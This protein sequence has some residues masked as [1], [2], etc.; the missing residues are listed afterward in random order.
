MILLTLHNLLILIITW[1]SAMDNLWTTVTEIVI[2]DAI[3]T[4]QLYWE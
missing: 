1:T 3:L 2:E 4:Q